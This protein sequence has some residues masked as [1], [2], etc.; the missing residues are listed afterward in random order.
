MKFTKKL[1]RW[2]QIAGGATVMGVIWA[3]TDETMKTIL[4]PKVGL[5]LGVAAVVLQG[6]AG[7]KAFD[8]SPDGEKL[9]KK[10]NEK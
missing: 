1:G 9:E 6:V 7:Q 3:G 8:Y 2:L 10:E 4:P 5:V